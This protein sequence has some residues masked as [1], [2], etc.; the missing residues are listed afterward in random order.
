MATDKRSIEITLKLNDAAD[1]DSNVSAKT[2]TSN[3]SNDKD[4]S[5]K[6][7]ATAFVLREAEVLANEI[8][9]Q[10][11]Y[12]WDRDLMLQDDYIGQ[13]EKR[14]A[15]TQIKRGISVG[16]GILSSAAAGAALAGPAAPA[17]AV[18]GAVL[19]TVN[20]VF[21]IVRSN[22]QGQDQQNIMLRQMNAQLD[23]TRSRAG[24]SLN[25]ASIGEDL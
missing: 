24:W 7:I 8:I 10:A 20:Q 19:G 2:D 12:V 14:I 18:I 5:V 15:L 4:K 16:T 9:A 1:D 21:G 3:K 22:Y 6:A 23:F 11:E 25:A 13:R 17:G